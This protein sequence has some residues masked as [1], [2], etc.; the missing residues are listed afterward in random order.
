VHC[1]EVQHIIGD[2]EIEKPIGFTVEEEI[3]MA[4]Q[5]VLE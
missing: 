3:S 1:S 4:E 5:C 2:G